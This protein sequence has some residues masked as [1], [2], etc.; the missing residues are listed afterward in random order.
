MARC[1]ADHIRRDG[2]VFEKGAVDGTG[3]ETSDQ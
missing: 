3:P 2:T 1:A